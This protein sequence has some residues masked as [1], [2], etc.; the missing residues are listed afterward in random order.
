MVYLIRSLRDCTGP[1]FTSIVDE[2]EHRYVYALCVLFIMCSVYYVLCIMCYVYYSMFKP[3]L[4]I[5]YVY[6]GMYNPLNMC[7]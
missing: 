3:P 5:V 4:Y 6:Y 2:V 1:A 7:I